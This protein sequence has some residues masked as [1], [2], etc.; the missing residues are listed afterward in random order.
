MCI[1]DR[2]N[3]V[4]GLPFHFEPKYICRTKNAKELERA[5]H[6]AF[7]DNRVNKRREFFEIDPERVF[8]ILKLFNAEDI[9][10]EVEKQPTTIDQESIDAEKKFKP[11]RP[12][13][14][15]EKIGVPIGSVL[16]SIKDPAFSATV[17]GAKRVK[18]GNEEMSLTEATR[19]A[20]KLATG[21]AIQPAP[22]WKFGE[23]SL[24]DLY[25]KIYGMAD[26]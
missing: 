10:S 15:F 5:L 16:Q 2:Y 25:E 6:D 4:T 19:R 11:K 14:D 13:L 9:T 17:V 20:H 8:A 18:V 24:Q 12:N 22:H 1:R 26:E 21:A 23:H 3:G 7:G